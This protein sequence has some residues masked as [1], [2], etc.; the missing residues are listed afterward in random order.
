MAAPSQTFG[1]FRFDMGERLLYR[2]SDPVPLTPKAAEALYWLLGRRGVLVEKDELMRLL[3]PDTIVEAATLSQHI[4]VLR[5]LLGSDGHDYIETI[6]RRGFRFKDVERKTAESVIGTKNRR[7]GIIALLASLIIL[8]AV[9]VV[10]KWRSDV[11]PPVETAT[12]AV[13]PFHPIE[14]DQDRYLGVAM[15]D[16]LI[17]RL[18]NIRGV[19]VRPTSAVRKFTAITD[20]VA[21]GRELGVGAVVEG[22]I[23]REDGHLRV[24]VQLVDI[25]RDAPRWSETFD[26][27]QSG[28]FSVQDRI[29]EKIAAALLINLNRQ[30]ARYTENAAAHND[31]LRGRYYWN[32]RT[33]DG[34]M[35]AIESFQHAIGKDPSYALAYDGL[36]DS[37]ALLGSMTNHFMPRSVAL[38]KAFAAVNRALQIDDNLSEAHASLGFLK[39]HYNWDWDGGEREFLRAIELNPSYATAHHW[40]AFE[41]VGLSRFDEAVH[42]IREAQKDDPVSIIIN[43]DVAEILY[44]AGR[45]DE[46]IAQCNRTIE[47]DPNFALAY[48]T[49]SRSQRSMGRY[50]EAAAAALKG[51]EI[52]PD[53][54]DFLIDLAGSY[55]ALGRPADAKK[56]IDEWR[57]RAAGSYDV[58]FDGNTKPHDP[59]NRE[60]AFAMLERLY[61]EHSGSLILLN[62]DPAYASIRDDPRFTNLVHRLG[63][64]RK[65][66]PKSMR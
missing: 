8:A 47:L 18:S 58:Y 42:E 27:P 34:Y 55:E 5:K 52:D 38:P 49:L 29:S 20:P 60:R 54:L 22:T 51:S 14:G 19:Q 30:S 16:A 37:Y 32:K 13:L 12:I 6:P 59:R 39:M 50:S 63:L 43:S 57:R 4:F 24:S 10:L 45:Y 21:A 23:Q 1:P 65:T 56:V 61:A 25:N 28:V 46:A 66:A 53:R 15:A 26:V 33:A 41:L 17:S 64:D 9:V 11:P 36:A 48:L 3:W 62:V 2:G 35:R 44:F 31:Y 40:Y 7:R